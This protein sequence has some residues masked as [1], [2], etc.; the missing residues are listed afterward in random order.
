MRAVRNRKSALRGNRLEAGLGV[1]RGGDVGRRQLQTV[2]RGQHF[3]MGRHGSDR[4]VAGHE[5]DRTRPQGRC[6]GEQILDQVRT[7][8]RAQFDFAAMAGAQGGLA[9]V[10]ISGDQRHI[11]QRQA[12]Q[13]TQAIDF[14][15]DHDGSRLR[16]VH[17]RA[18]R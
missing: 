10:D 3:A 18:S 12:A 14:D 7:R 4:F 8:Q 13:D 11:A 6:Q 17:C 1:Q 5:Q 2:M 15:T 16:Q 9:Q